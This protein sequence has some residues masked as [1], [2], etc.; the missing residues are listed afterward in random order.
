MRFRLASSFKKKDNMMKNILLLF[1]GVL[2]CVSCKK[3]PYSDFML[4]EKVDSEEVVSKN[5]YIERLGVSSKSA[6][7]TLLP[8]RKVKVVR[9][10]Y[11][12]VDPFGNDIIAS[13]IV[14]YP[15][16]FDNNETAGAVLGEHFTICSNAETPSVRMAAHEGLFA[17]FN[18]V[19]VNPDYIGYG[20]TNDKIHP[21][22]IAQNTGQ[23][24]V[25]MLLAAKEYFA[26]QNKRFPRNVT[27]VGYSEGGH[28]SMSALKHIEEKYEDWFHL[29][30]VFAGAGAY[31]LTA[32]Y[33][34]IMESDYTSLAVS[35]P[36]MLLG[37]DYGENLGMDFQ[38]IFKEPLRSKY[39]EWILSKKYS[40][41]AASDSIG[42]TKL[43]KFLNIEELEKQANLKVALE[44]NTLLRKTWYPRTKVWLVHGNK[45]SVV[46][47]LNSESALKE[48]KAK[49]S[50]IDLKV[51]EGKDHLEA[52]NDF[53]A[54]CMLKMLTSSSK[55][56]G[57]IITEYPELVELLE[58]SNEPLFNIK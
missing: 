4:L 42:S 44:K 8:D 37:I 26:S 24:S 43:S 15:A 41:R 46:P 32:T 39:S 17:L 23:V 10:L 53:Y 56:D 12:T 55:T 14:S 51:I 22:H 21:Y 36:L 49:G 16:S 47:F 30:E 7:G 45:D 29:K 58:N 5:T 20:K 11:N 6:L 25:D 35:V 38:T 52:G 2:L 34:H 54:F 40:T 9:L 18:Y 19:V 50:D 13:G 28:S 57:A 3:A 31:D 33:K 48:F 27:I 1:L